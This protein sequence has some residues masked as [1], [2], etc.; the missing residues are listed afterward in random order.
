MLDL[1]NVVGCLALSR[2]AQGFFLHF[3][4]KNNPKKNYEFVERGIPKKN[5]F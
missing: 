2:P 5:H 3:P 4:K 1:G